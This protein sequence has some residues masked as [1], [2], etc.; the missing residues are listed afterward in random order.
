VHCSTKTWALFGLNIA[1][2]FIFCFNLAQQKAV[3][4]TGELL[5]LA[6][7]AQKYP[8]VI[9]YLISFSVAGAI[10]QVGLLDKQVDDMHNIF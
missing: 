8:Y 6:I 7:F 4:V 1:F 5:E 10:G 2:L 9:L 3:V